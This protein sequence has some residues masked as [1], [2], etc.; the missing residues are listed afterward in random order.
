MTGIMVKARAASPH[1]REGFA[2][3]PQHGTA[4]VPNFNP[5]AR[6][7]R[8]LEYFT[9]G[10]FLWR[11]RI[12]FLP[13]L[14]HCRRALVL[15]D[16]DGRFTARLLRE[17]PNLEVTAID[18]SPRMIASLQRASM[19]YAARLTTEVAD[20]RTWRPADSAK[21]DLIVTH[22]FLDCLTTQEVHDL[23]VRLIPAISPDGL[24][25]VSEFAIPPT[26]FG[27]TVATPLIWLLY[28]AFRMFT[29]LGP[30]SLPS[31]TEALGASSWALQIERA[32]MR[33]LLLSQLW[34]HSRPASESRQPSGSS[35]GKMDLH[36]AGRRHL[37]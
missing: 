32:H 17:N 26:L 9:F 27:R 18:G 37:L 14:V 3:N 31:Y 23:A 15:G 28:R 12:H 10:P 11:C 16:G 6:I 19:R 13:Q 34:R 5:L 21:Y 4:G 1:S 33:G 36:N 8:W 29:G 22:F 2:A 25:L 24:W 20:L 35:T 7:Y 30:Q